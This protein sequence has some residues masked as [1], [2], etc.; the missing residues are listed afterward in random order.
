MPP[1]AGPAPVA[2]TDLLGEPE[3]TELHR[4]GHLR[5]YPRLASIVVEGA[6]GDYAFLL[7]EGRVKV[8]TVSSD[9][10]EAVLAVLGPGDLVGEF[11]AIAGDGGP[12]TASNVTLEP[13]TCRLIGGDEF[14]RFLDTHPAV[15]RSMLRVIVARLRA[16]DRRRAETASLDTVHRLARFLLELAERQGPGHAGEVDLDLPLSQDE[17]ASLIA[18]SRE[19]IVR[20]LAKLRRLGL[21]ETGRRRITILD[22]E[23]LRRFAG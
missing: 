2:L 9:G 5:H 11:E 21:I 12:R 8:V 4:L 3:R 23:G 15:A 17:V 1:P 10:R 22:R 14:N 13:V 18:G 19:A 20:S 16:A 7:L 6:T